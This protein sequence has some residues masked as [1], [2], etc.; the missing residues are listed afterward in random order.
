MLSA[1]CETTS[2]PAGLEELNATVELVSLRG[3]AELDELD[4]IQTLERR[5]EPGKAVDAEAINGFALTDTKLVDSNEPEVNLEMDDERELEG[6]ELDGT[7]GLEDEIEDTKEERREDEDDE[8]EAK[9]EFTAS[10]EV[11]AFVRGE[12]KD[13]VE[14]LSVRSVEPAART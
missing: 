9:V 1:N 8:D 14:G 4:P 11:S 10:A 5:G 6:R 12:S 13:C 7:E 2:E 3:I